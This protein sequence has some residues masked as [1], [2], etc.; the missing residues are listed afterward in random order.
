MNAEAVD[1][2]G[3]ELGRPW[4]LLPSAAGMLSR[5]PGV[6]A[7]ARPSGAGRAGG[8]AYR[9]VSDRDGIA[10]VDLSGLLV[11]F[12]DSPWTTATV[13]LGDTLR[14][15]RVD[16][17]IRGVMIRCY[18]PGGTIDG[19]DAL[20][21]EIAALAAA[22]PT[23][24][25][26]EDLCASAAVWCVSQTSVIS[27]NETAEVGSIGVYMAVADWSE[28]ATREGIRVHLIRAGE[29]HKGA[30]VPGTV[31]EDE[32]VAKWQSYVERH[33]ATFLDRVAAGRNMPR[34]DVVKLNDG[35]VWI[36]DD[37]VRVGLVDH[38]EDFDAALGRL[39]DKA[40]AVSPKP[41]TPSRR[42]GV[43]QFADDTIVA[44][45]AMADQIAPG[46]WNFY[47]KCKAVKERW[48]VARL[49]AAASDKPARPKDWIR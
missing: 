2:L 31:V 6:V 35:S 19:C 4:A 18:S 15:L 12:L 40:D 38:I 10:V 17:S 5:L 21:K 34:A 13:A 23:H 22:K 39:R 27:A 20:G 45:E 44:S 8:A 25:Y 37:A 1:S 36:G 43:A 11:K 14:R 49:R 47:A 32:H 26:C 7:P 33:N 16:E 9:T 41:S 24:G 30:G 46:D 3:L 48:S 29:P 28:H 42:R